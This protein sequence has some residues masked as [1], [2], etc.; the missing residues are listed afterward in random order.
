ML[1]LL[2]NAALFL[3]AT[4]YWGL[5]T[6]KLQKLSMIAVMMTK[7]G[8]AGSWPLSIIVSSVNTFTSPY[9]QADISLVLYKASCLSWCPSCLHHWDLYRLHECCANSAHGWVAYCASI[10]AWYFWSFFSVSYFNTQ[11]CLCEQHSAFTLLLLHFVDPLWS[12]SIV[13]RSF[14][15]CE[16]FCMVENCIKILHNFQIQVGTLKS[17][18]DIKAELYTKILGKFAHRREVECGIKTGSE[19]KSTLLQ[20]KAGALQALCHST[21]SHSQVHQ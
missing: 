21:V 10:G 15:R 20:H 12:Y 6:C 19:F 16:Y 5:G 13:W 7:P 3:S 4:A 8:G 1:R 2:Q 18:E 11:D 9:L 17:Q 14:N